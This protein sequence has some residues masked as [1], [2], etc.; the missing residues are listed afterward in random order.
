MYGHTC[1]VHLTVYECMDINILNQD[2]NV[3]DIDDMFCSML[4]LKRYV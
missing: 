1:A 4:H 2:V 3:L